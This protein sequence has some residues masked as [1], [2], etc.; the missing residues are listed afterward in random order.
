VRGCKQDL[1]RNLAPIFQIIRME[2][3]QVT[4]APKNSERTEK[5]VHSASQLFARQGYHGTSTREIARLADISENTLF[6]HFEHKEDIFWAALRAGLNGFQLRKGLIEGITEC[7]PPEVVLPQI[8][9]L[10]VD[11]VS[12]KPEL[13]CRIAVALIELRWKAE[14]ICNKHLSPIFAAFRQYLATN[15]ESG[16][17]RNLDPGMVTAALGMTVLVHPE[18]SRLISG[19]PPAHND[20]REAIR[21]YSKFWL[22]VLVLQR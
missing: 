6:R 13:L 10:I 12:F 11:T 20:T 21:A 18:L 15:I 4:L 3:K 1:P 14:T 22:D 19:E 7:H 16:R 2:S 9:G 8:L 17:I 5:I